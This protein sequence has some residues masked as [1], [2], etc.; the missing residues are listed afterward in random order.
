M[1]AFPGCG[2]EALGPIL[3]RLLDCLASAM[4]DCETPPCRIFLSTAELVPWD[5]CCSCGD[6]VGQ[7]W[8]S[9]TNIR[10]LLTPTQGAGP[11]RC[12][13]IYEATVHLG[14]VRCA[15]TSDDNGN[16]PDPTDLTDETLGILQDRMI[17]TRALSLCFAQ[18]IE[19]DDWTIGEWDSLG[20]AGGCIGGQL[21]VTLRFNDRC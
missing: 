4:E 13:S 1:G 20:P 16:A 6:G 9:V 5:M 21:S 2:T 7:A 19:L 18:T 17:M 10:P 12:T 8:V 14:I 15:L 11:V 3:N